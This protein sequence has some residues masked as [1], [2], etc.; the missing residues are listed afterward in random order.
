MCRL[1]GYKFETTKD[2]PYNFPRTTSCCRRGGC[3]LCYK[4][5]CRST[6]LTIN[7]C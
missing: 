3:S 2:L 7:D 5:W 4:E 1:Y 6:C